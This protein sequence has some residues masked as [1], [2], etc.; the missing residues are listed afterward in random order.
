VSFGWLSS[1]RE[2]IGELNL[3]ITPMPGEA[4]VWNCFTLEPHRRHGH[5]RSLLC[6]LVGLPGINRLWIGSVDIPAEKADSDAGFVRVLRFDVVHERGVRH[7]SAR[8]AP[9]ADRGLVD[10]ARSRLALEGWTHSA[11]DEVRVH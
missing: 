9:G 3:W 2:W 11:A 1:E 5:Y 4:Y 7:L 10:E 8:A 6:G